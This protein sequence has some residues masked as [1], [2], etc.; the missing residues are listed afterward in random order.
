MILKKIFFKLQF[1]IM[2]YIDYI[3]VIGESY[4]SGAIF[5]ETNHCAWGGRCKWS[6]DHTIETRAGERASL[7]DR[8]SMVGVCSFEQPFGCHSNVLGELMEAHFNNTELS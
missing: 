6:F 4:F 5:S 7:L 8:F 2:H 1:K 3:G